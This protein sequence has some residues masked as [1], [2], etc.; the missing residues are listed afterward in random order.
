MKRRETIMKIV[1]VGECMIEISG[2]GQPDLWRVGFAGDTLNT[3][4]YLAQLVPQGWSV[5]Y[6]TMLGQ[7]PHSDSMLAFLERSGL[8]TS[9]ITRHPTR[10][11]GLYMIKL[12][13]GERA[14]TYWRDCSAARCLADDPAKLAEVIGGADVVYLSGITL[15][16]LPPSGREALLTQLADSESHV[17]FDPNLRPKLWSDPAEMREWISRAGAAARTVLPSYDD[18][19]VHFGDADPHATAER[20]LALGARDVIVK[21]GGGVMVHGGPDGVRDLPEL[22]RQTPV[23]TTGA[24]DSFNA[25]FLA[26]FLNGSSIDA[27]V[28]DAHQVALQ[29]I[30]SHGALCPV[31][32][33]NGGTVR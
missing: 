26:R 14:F 13:D 9:T 27:A 22:P 19:A 17:V 33:G 10:V 32:G 5:G 29:V 8:D 15:A 18:E 24:G 11:P 31:E 7:D 1:S 3:A 12:H 30:A 6:H 2:S 23:D 20:Y 21:N 28:R 25:G 16:I 4:W